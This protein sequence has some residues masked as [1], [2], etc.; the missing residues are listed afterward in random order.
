MTFE[1][2]KKQCINYIK[3]ADYIQPYSKKIIIERLE[4]KKKKTC[5]DTL[6]NYCIELAI[7]LY[8]KKEISEKE[9]SGIY[10]QMSLYF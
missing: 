3:K 2:Y 8:S 7:Q 1:E 5:N 9:Y 10:S 6:Y 4:G